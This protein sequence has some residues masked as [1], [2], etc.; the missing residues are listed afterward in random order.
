MAL[1]TSG[2]AALGIA[3]GLLTE[4]MASVAGMPSWVTVAS[5]LVLLGAAGF[6][7]V[8]IQ[9]RD[10]GDALDLFEAVLAPAIF[11]L[12]PLTVVLVVALAQGLS[13]SLQRIQ[14]TKA[15]FNVAQWMSAAAA[16]SFVFHLLRP[17][18]TLGPGNLWALVVAML[19][20]SVVNLIAL[21]AVLL[22]ARQQP[23]KAVLADLAPAIVRGSLIGWTVNVAFG[24][25]FSATAAWVPQA[26]L[27]WLVPLAVLYWANRAYASVRADRT[28]LAGMQLAT[29]AL[30]VPM[31]P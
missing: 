4:S 20:V 7:T 30:A 19:A 22:I 18:G 11:L 9:F 21:V 15:C 10:Q 24:V 6:S 23:L 16:G 17:D 26:I 14:P 27:L 29:H 5:F 25:I 3:G 28:R 8:E 2:L 13:E 31:N 1:L 12:P